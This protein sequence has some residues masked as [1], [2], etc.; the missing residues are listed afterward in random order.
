MAAMV[1]ISITNILFKIS[2][3]DFQNRVYKEITHI[4]VKYLELQ[5]PTDDVK[6]KTYFAANTNFNSKKEKRKV[7][8]YVKELQKSIK[9]NWEPPF[10]IIN[11]KIV[12]LLGITRDGQINELTLLS[13][14]DDGLAAGRALEA[15][16]KAAP[17]KHL[18]KEFKGKSLKVQLTFDYN[19][20]DIISYNF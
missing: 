13:P 17:F 1:F 6:Q 7:E 18:P 2:P 4:E 3:K 16:T 10:E 8:P 9:S 15:I 14:L 12:L 20:F 5:I 19:I 11:K